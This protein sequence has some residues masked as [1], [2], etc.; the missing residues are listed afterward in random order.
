MT[1]RRRRQ[2]EQ[3]A[4]KKKAE[5]KHEARRELTRR[6]VIAL[7]FGVVVVT[8]F[9]LGT[10]LGGGEDK[11]PSG[12]EG[13]RNQDTACGAQAPAPEPVVTFE[14]PVLQDDITADSVVT[15]TIETSCGP[16][17]IELDPAISPQTVNSFVFLARQGFYD[18]QVFYRIFDGF[19]VEAGDPTADG[20]GGPGY[21]VPDEFPPSDFE[22]VKDVV[23]MANQGKRTTGS[24][25][26]IVLSD[27]AAALNPVFNVLGRLTSG[28]DTLDRMVQVPVARRPGT[29]EDSLPLET[30]Y[31]ESVTIDVAGS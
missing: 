9:S 27:D 28:H 15:A 1:D 16:L 22:Y 26:F 10:F 29:R 14:E 5:K 3:R 30:V 6:L 19:K 18:G 17:V 11:L 8:L 23:A 25:F 2:K 20:T 4:A 7:G 12:Y 21:R 24:Q 31:I 13:F